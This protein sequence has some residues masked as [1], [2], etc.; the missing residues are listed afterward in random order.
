MRTPAHPGPR[1]LARESRTDQGARS[2][3]QLLRLAEQLLPQR[4]VEGSARRFRNGV[5]VV[6][7]VDGTSVHC[8]AAITL[9]GLSQPGLCPVSV[10]LDGSN[11]DGENRRRLFFTV[12]R[13]ESAVDQLCE[14]RIGSI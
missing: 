12:S 13:K 1:Q 5:L 11:R 7:A 14:P 10:A 6:D 9:H 2:S 4:A 8:R 3:L